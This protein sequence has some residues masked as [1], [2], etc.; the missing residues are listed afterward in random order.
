MQL[1]SWRRCDSS[2]KASHAAKHKDWNPKDIH[3]RAGAK[4]PGGL[5]DI[6]AGIN[7]PSASLLALVL[8][9][10]TVLKQMQYAVQHIL[11]YA[12]IFLCQLQLFKFCE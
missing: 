6:Y 11:Q 12:V 10:F 9:F 4:A 8:L 1:R 2:Y 5:L 7:H 3:A